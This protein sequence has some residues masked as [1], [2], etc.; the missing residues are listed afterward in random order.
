M[1]KS[2]LLWALWL[3]VLPLWAK[4]QTPESIAE[5]IQRVNNNWQSN[6]TYKTR[7]F[8]DDA[9]YHIGNMEVVQLFPK[10]D[11]TG[12]SMRWAIHNRWQGATEK[13]PKK[14]KYQHYG[15]YQF[16]VLFGDWQTC[17][18][19]YI[20]LYKI[21]PTKDKITRTKEV[22]SYMAD[23]PESDYW[24]WADALFMSMP[25]MT[26][27]YKLTGEQKYL[28]KMYS[29]ILFTD[30]LMYDHE[31]G[32]YFRDAKYVYPK[33]KTNLGKKDFWARADGWVLAGLAK[34]LQDLPKDY[35][36]YDFFVEKYRRLA[37]AA[38][39]LQQRGG[40]WTR[41]MMDP[42]QAPGPETSGTELLTYGLLWGI[43]N[44]ILPMKSYKKTVERA[45]NYL[46]NTAL[47]PDGR[48]G[49]VQPIG[50]KAIPDQIVDR[51][52][53]TNFGVGGFLLAAC[54]YYRYLK[55]GT[56]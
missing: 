11:F 29:C 3:G 48:V 54:E 43:N 38:A 55:A 1:K 19:T 10:S 8:W 35:Q 45:W 9:V 41:S 17:F 34:V 5:I 53:E 27:M 16:H 24:W 40:Y 7:A 37:A 42:R 14:W 51:N 56:K 47:Q 49:Y 30:S 33:H 50:E 31:T 36:H 4:Q 52:S 2:I 13:D 20:D 23:A 18:Q 32:L 15:E 26:K 12:Y 6:H 46:Q 21:S 22:M 39:K 28:D 44:G 25:V